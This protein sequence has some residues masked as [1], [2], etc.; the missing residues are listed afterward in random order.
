MSIFSNSLVSHQTWQ[1]CNTQILHSSFLY[2]EVLATYVNKLYVSKTVKSWTWNITA[3]FRMTN[4]YRILA[5]YKNSW[6]TLDNKFTFWI[7]ACPKRGK[8]WQIHRS[9]LLP[10]SCLV[11]HL[12]FQVKSV[13]QQTIR[14]PLDIIPFSWQL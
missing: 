13:H 12:C 3:W 9:N 11:L 10:L 6:R 14:L 7:I 1:P 4:K 5:V 8:T 2:L